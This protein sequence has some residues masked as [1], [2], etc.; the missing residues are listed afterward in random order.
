MKSTDCTTYERTI[1]SSQDQA[2]DMQLEV[3]QRS[4]KDPTVKDLREASVKIYMLKVKV[5]F[6]NAK[7]Y[8][9]FAKTGAE[10]GMRR[11][12]EVPQTW[13]GTEKQKKQCYVWNKTHKSQVQE[14]FCPVKS[15]AN[16][17]A[18]SLWVCPSNWCFPKGASCKPLAQKYPTCSIWYELTSKQKY[19]KIKGRKCKILTKALRSRC[20]WK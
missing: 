3:D 6:W 12:A 20:R 15:C 7:L 2:E 17:L 18:S 14:A 5:T 13:F 8:P 9:L 11:M 10:A 19:L 16:Q 1:Q 4:H